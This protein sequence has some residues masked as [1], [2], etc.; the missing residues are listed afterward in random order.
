MCLGKSAVNFFWFSICF[1]QGFRTT[2]F[3]KHEDWIQ[4]PS[5]SPSP[6]K[7]VDRALSRPLCRNSPASISISPTYDRL[8]TSTN[9][10][11]RGCLS[12]PSPSISPMP[13]P[14][15][16]LVVNGAAKSEMTFTSQGAVTSLVRDIKAMARFGPSDSFVF[17][18][19]AATNSVTPSAHQYQ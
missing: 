19:I 9:L 5:L 16:Y 18:A 12:F 10:Q 6:S 17:G 7:V 13:S 4:A 3:R 14:C 8:G 2:K 1:H 11:E 15:E